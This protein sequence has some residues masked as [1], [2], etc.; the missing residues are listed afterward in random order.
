MGCAQPPFDKDPLVMTPY[1][2]V[3][4]VPRHIFTLLN[5][6]FHQTFERFSLLFIITTQTRCCLSRYYAFSVL[7]LCVLFQPWTCLDRSVERWRNRFPHTD[8]QSLHEWAD[9]TGQRQQNYLW[10]KANRG[11]WTHVPLSICCDEKDIAWVC[12]VSTAYLPTI[13]PVTLTAPGS[14]CWVKLLLRG[15]TEHIFINM[16]TFFPHITDADKSQQIWFFH[17]FK[18]HK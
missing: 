11:K 8:G 1:N 10:P 5:I 17:F 9:L 4:F 3:D 2:V 6:R 13:F 14:C 7:F 12:S 15:F 18:R 16:I